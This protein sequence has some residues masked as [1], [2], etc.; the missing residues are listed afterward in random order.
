VLTRRS[1]LDG[2]GSRAR[3]GRALQHRSRSDP[4][5]GRRRCS[6]VRSG[7][8]PRCHPISSRSAEFTSL[9]VPTMTR[10]PLLAAWPRGEG[11]ARVAPTGTTT[12]RHIGPE[13]SL[14]RQT[15]PAETQ[16]KS[17]TF[18]PNGGVRS[19][20][21]S[22]CRPPRQPSLAQAMTPPM[23]NASPLR[24]TLPERPNAANLAPRPS[25]LL[26]T[27]LNPTC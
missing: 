19:A 2:E 24:G 3:R 8:I 15:A 26:T 9:L 12:A 18:P 27:P 11:P 20:H 14:E 22:P 21:S 10:G 1:L 4:S 17:E 23:P 7:S 5:V 16:R 6:L 25:R 13:P